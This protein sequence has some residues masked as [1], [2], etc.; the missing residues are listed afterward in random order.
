ML[1]ATVGEGVDVDFWSYQTKDGRGIRKALDWLGPYISGTEKWPYAQIEAYNPAEM[2]PALLRAARS[3]KDP[4][5]P[6]WVR[7]EDLSKDVPTMLL[8]LAAGK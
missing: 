3:Y 4:R 7:P 5:Y 8:R 6:S 2:A 1:L